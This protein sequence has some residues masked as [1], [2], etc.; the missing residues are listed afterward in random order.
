M[1]NNITNQKFTAV[2]ANHLSKKNKEYFCLEIVIHPT[3]TKKVFLDES[4]LA[5]ITALNQTEFTATV[6]QNIA[7]ESGNP[8]PTLDIQLTAECV[9]KSLIERAEMALIKLND[10]PF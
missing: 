7:K 4:E 2:L 9:K 1:K 10:Q 5:L 8:Y 3:Y 6:E